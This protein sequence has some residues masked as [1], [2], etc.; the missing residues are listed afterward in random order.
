MHSSNALILLCFSNVHNLLV[1]FFYQALNPK[2]RK[3]HEEK[4]LYWH[5]DSLR[6]PLLPGDLHACVRT[7]VL[8]FC[9]LGRRKTSDQSNLTCDQDLGKLAVLQDSL[10]CMEDFG[11]FVHLTTICFGILF[12]LTAKTNLCYWICCLQCRGYRWVLCS[13][14]NLSNFCYFGTKKLHFTI[15][16][17]PE[18]L[19]VLSYSSS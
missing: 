13:G 2:V 9:C 4:F 5:F 7:Q 16:L 3:E 1:Y 17:H 6:S 12:S 18:T 14:T 19:K 11:G 8:I 15:S 10:A